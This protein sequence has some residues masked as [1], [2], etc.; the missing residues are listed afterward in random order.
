MSTRAS[1]AAVTT[2]LKNWLQSSVAG[3]IGPDITATTLRPDR[4]EAGEGSKINLYLFQITPNHGYRNIDQPVRRSDGGLAVKPRTAIDLHYL[5]SFYTKDND[6]LPQ[7]LLAK[8]IEVLNSSPGIAPGKFKSLLATESA[9]LQAAPIGDQ[10][11]LVKITHQPVPLEEMAR[12]WSLFPETKYLLSTVY[13]VTTVILEADIEPEP[14]LPILSPSVGVGAFGAPEVGAASLVGTDAVPKLRLS[15]SRFTDD[16][17]IEIDG[18]AAIPASLVDGGLE[19]PIAPSLTLGS[20]TARALRP[21][22]VGNR[23][24]WLD[25]STV[26]FL[27][28]PVIQKV[29][30]VGGDITVTLEREAIQGQLPTLLLNRTAG[31]GDPVVKISRAPLSNLET[32]S[33][34]FD[35]PAGLS[36][37]FSVRV[38]I[39][40]A[41]SLLRVSGGAPSPQVTLP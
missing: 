12:I 1:V 27:L 2:A 25:S 9:E 21:V 5:L 28:R 14:A 31:S 23:T 11:E 37:T 6:L 40:E 18:A 15:G 13:C 4:I 29:V 39:D 41:D 7:I 32:S 10:Q 35:L 8:T 17:L 36:G 20:H 16:C 33:L 30:Q 3:K 38:R 24:F 26:P 22:A 19:C 34:P